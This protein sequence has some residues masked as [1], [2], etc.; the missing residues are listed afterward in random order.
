M[1]ADLHLWVGVVDQLQTMHHN[2]AKRHVDLVAITR[3]L[4]GALAIDLDST[5]DGR[6]LL[7]FTRPLRKRLLHLLTGRLQRR[8][9]RHL[10]LRITRT[11]GLS[12]Y[13]SCLIDFVELSI[14]AG[15]LALFADYDNHEP[16]RKGVERAS[17]PYFY[18][19]ARCLAQ[20]APNAR[21]DAKTG[22]VGWL[23]NQKNSICHLSYY[24]R[25]MK[26]I[27]FGIFAH[28]DDEA[29]GPSGTLLM[30]TK[31]GTELHLITL[32]TGQAGMN[33]DNHPDLGAVREQEW[34]TAGQ[35]IGAST[36]HALGFE[37]GHL[38]NIAMQEAATRITRLVE[39]VLAAADPETIVEFMSIDTNGIT[40]HIDHIVAG[41]A[42]CLVFYR[43]KA[44]DSRVTRLRLA[45]IPEARLPDVNTDWLYM[46]AGRSD[47]EIDEVVDAREYRDDIIAIMRAHHTQRGDC[48]ANLARQGEMLGMN[49]FIVKE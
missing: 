18:L 25:L 34:R 46:E 35:L 6:T 36:M 4:I 26:K 5:E 24:T 16:R 28:P 44:R 39:D 7:D 33:P 47:A 31:S 27:I 8:D 41:R 37:D 30:E 45:C 13:E 23:I 21:H 40:G 43:L 48:E 38:D 14:D 22:H 12:K 3:Q 15:L 42:A 19:L 29:F 17:M 49:Y 1:R 11:A 10:P 2:R 20:H 32:T 9:I